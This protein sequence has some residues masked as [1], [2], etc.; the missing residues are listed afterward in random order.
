LALLFLSFALGTALSTLNLFFP[1][2][3]GQR[4]SVLSWLAG[5]LSGE[6]APHAA[7]FQLLVSG[8]FVLLGALEQPAGQLALAL[9]VASWIGQAAAYGRSLGARYPL[10]AALGELDLGADLPRFPALREVLQPLPL[11]PPEVEHLRGIPFA[12]AGGVELMMDVFR[13]RAPGPPRP[14]LLQIHGGAWIVGSRVNQ[15][16]PLMRHMAQRGWICATIDYRLSPR[17]TFPE[18]LID[19]KR[20]LQYLRERGHE[21]GGDPGFVIATGGSAGGQLCALLGLTAN[22]PEY[23]P[24]FEAVDTS[25]RACVPFYGVYET[26]DFEGAYSN[27]GLKELL[28]QTVLKISLEADPEAYHRASPIAQAHESAPPFFLIHGDRD[29]LVPVEV[30][31]RFRD[32]LRSKSQNPVLYAELP[33]AQ[34]AF[35]VLRSPRTLY[36]V[37][38]VAGFCEWVRARD[39]GSPVAPGLSAS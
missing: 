10:E 22:Q 29:S 33:G 5:L 30:A 37:E 28:E 1:W 16:R 24:G 31:R 7:I 38:A 25:V 35:E 2:F 18:H 3:A 34:H 13:P 9:M 19:C 36:A 6:L 11:T 27:N 20:A 17:A 14:M 23:Q 39:M 12:R 8:G 32:A 4:R 21:L 26:V 15:A